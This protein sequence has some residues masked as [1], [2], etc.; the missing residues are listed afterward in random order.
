MYILNKAEF[1]SSG[2]LSQGTPGRCSTVCPKFGLR[3]VRWF[4]NFKK[5]M[6][7]LIFNIFIRFEYLSFSKCQVGKISK[8]KIIL[9]LWIL[10]WLK[11]IIDKNFWCWTGLKLGIVG[12]S[13]SR[14]GLLCIE[15]YLIILD[16]LLNNLIIILKTA[17][18]IFLC[19]IFIKK[20]FK[21]IF[22]ILFKNCILILLYSE[23]VTSLLLPVGMVSLGITRIGHFKP[24]LLY[25]CPIFRLIFR[26][27][28]L[29]F[30]IFVLF[31]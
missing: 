14:L 7:G 13:W 31:R 10:N 5:K 3:T 8:P 30:M 24:W 12:L 23:R 6:S 16:G 21:I 28:L 9:E 20:Y 22:K 11:L 25:L 1:Y 26:I 18:S 27:F 17:C 15:N 29:R 19:V 4:C 2:V